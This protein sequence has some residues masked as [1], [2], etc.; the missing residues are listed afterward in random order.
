MSHTHRER[1]RHRQRDKQA[2]CGEPDAGLDPRT[3]GSQ[4]E[5]KVDTQP[6]S[7]QDAARQSLFRKN[8]CDR[9][10]TSGLKSKSSMG[11]WNFIANEY[12]EVK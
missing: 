6:L 10:K 1:Q 2:P 8:N 4:P 12:G 3:P 9:R 5:P 11:K 7:H